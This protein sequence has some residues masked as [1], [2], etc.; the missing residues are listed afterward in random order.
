[1]ALDRRTLLTFGLFGVAL[2]AAPAALA[3]ETHPLPRRGDY[4]PQEVLQQGPKADYA[5]ARLRK[6]PAGY[7][8]YQIGRA[9]VLASVATGL[10]VEVVLL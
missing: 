5:A 8:W 2:A 1:M 10:I 9:Y 3:Q 4:L 6:P 7:G